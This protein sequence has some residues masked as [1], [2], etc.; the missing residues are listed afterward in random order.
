MAIRETASRLRRWV[1]NGDVLDGYRMVSM[2]NRH[3]MTTASPE[4]FPV[5]IGGGVL[6]QLNSIAYGQRQVDVGGVPAIGGDAKQV[7]TVARFSLVCFSG[8]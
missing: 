7:T 3:S 6:A 4:R 5:G 8:S 1:E 2:T